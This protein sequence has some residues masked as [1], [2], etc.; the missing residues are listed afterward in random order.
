MKRAGYVA[1]TR[2]KINAHRVLLGKRE[3][4]RPLKGPRYRWKYSIDVK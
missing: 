3:A 2:G 1:C 4:M